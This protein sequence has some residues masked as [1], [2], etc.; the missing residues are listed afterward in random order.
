[1]AKKTVVEEDVFDLFGE[2]GGNFDGIDLDNLSDMDDD[3]TDIEDDEEEQEEEVDKPKK[4]KQ[5]KSEE[6]IEPEDDEEDDDDSIEQNRSALRIFAEMNR[7][8]GIIE[9]KDE[10][11]EDSEDFLLNKVQDTIAAKTAEGIEEYKKSLPAKVK[12]IIDNYEEGVGLDAIIQNKKSLDY[13]EKITDEKIEED[14]HL[15][16]NLVKE[17]YKSKG[18]SEEKIDKKITRLKINQDLEEEAKEALEEI[19][20]I[21]KEELEQIKKQQKAE[22]EYRVKKHNEWVD[23]FKKDIEGRSEILKG[24]PI[25]AQD[26]KDLQDAILKIDKNGKNEM[27]RIR[28]ADPDFDLK[29]LYMAKV[30]NWNIG[31]IKATSKSEATKSLMDAL[32]NNGNFRDRNVNVKSSVSEKVIKN[33]L[34]QNSGF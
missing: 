22:E 29:V 1:M 5:T 6:R 23:S 34:R 21:K 12:D 10:E 26:K 27:M 17:Y 11:Y 19:I 32:S 33:A 8:K 14:E 3:P 25:S 2:E 20:D 31:K 24:I 15:Q 7:E 13:Y 16:E 9:F 30:L 28:E 18:F 4:T